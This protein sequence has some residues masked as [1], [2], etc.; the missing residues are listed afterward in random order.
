MNKS[1]SNSKQ[2]K[3]P[4]NVYYCIDPNYVL[5]KLVSFNDD[6]NDNNQNSEQHNQDNNNNN[7]IDNEQEYDNDGMNNDENDSLRDNDNSDTS[8]NKQLN[9][10]STLPKPYTQCKPLTINLHWTLTKLLKKLYSNEKLTWPYD[11]DITNDNDINDTVIMKPTIDNNN[12]TNA[13]VFNNEDNNAIDNSANNY[14]LL[15]QILQ[16]SYIKVTRD[17]N[18]ITHRIYHYRKPDKNNQ[19]SN[20]DN[21]FTLL[22]LLTEY[23]L[24]HT[25][26]FSSDQISNKHSLTSLHIDKF[27]I[28]L[29]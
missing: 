23:Q 27:V 21:E 10:T 22:Q 14:M 13:E 29:Q 26:Q 8:N 17:S 16:H 28:M 4:V 9:T 25:V 20:I 6:Q 24:F 18:T 15:L 12:N 5:P 11:N 19:Y 1:K 7:N 2:L 3:Q